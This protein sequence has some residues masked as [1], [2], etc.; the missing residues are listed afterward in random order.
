MFC[1]DLIQHWKVGGKEGRS[2]KEGNMV[3]SWRE[4]EK[5]RDRKE[6]GRGGREGEEGGE[7]GE[8]RGKRDGERGKE[9]EGQGKGEREE[10]SEKKDEMVGEKGIKRLTEEGEKG[11]R[12][13]D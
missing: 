6:G 11:E 5:G 12:V 8:G 7:K 3:G 9:K 10:G 2:K 13:D 4:K 1:W